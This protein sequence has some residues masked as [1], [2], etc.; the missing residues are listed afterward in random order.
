MTLTE[1]L[2]R[3]THDTAQAHGGSPRGVVVAP[4]LFR[5]LADEQGRDPPVVS[6]LVVLPTAA[7][8]PATD[9]LPGASERVE[10]PG[11]DRVSIYVGVDPQASA[12]PPGLDPAMP[13]VFVPVPPD[14]L[15]DWSGLE[16]YS[17]LR[18][19]GLSPEEALAGARP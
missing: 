2:E 16:T 8:A 5:H 10:I 11:P 4:E 6:E 12:F 9:D 1:I 18:W 19:F 14:R 7:E 13:V 15:D 17:Q 3:W